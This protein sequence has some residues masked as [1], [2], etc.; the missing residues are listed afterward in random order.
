MKCGNCWRFEQLEAKVEQGEKV[1]QQEVADAA[2]VGQAA[3]A[4]AIGRSDKNVQQNGN[5]TDPGESTLKDRRYEALVKIDGMKARIAAGGLSSG[6]IEA[7]D[8]RPIGLHVDRHFVVTDG[9]G[10]GVSQ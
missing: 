5:V 8:H 10:R 3:V 2:G 4:M 9:L 7:H 1:T 6:Q